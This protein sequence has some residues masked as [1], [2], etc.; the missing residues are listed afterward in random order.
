MG[1]TTNNEVATFEQLKA[2]AA[3]KRR[4]NTTDPLPICGL[5]FRMRSVFEDELSDY[6]AAIQAAKDAQQRHVRLRAANRQ[7]IALVLVD[8][9]G[10]P[11]VP[12]GEVDILRDLDAAD[13]S[14]LY[15]DCVAHCGVNKQDLED[16]V[17]NSE[18][19]TP[20]DSPTS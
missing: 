8:T 17:G 11:L 19:T 9:L 7:F 16:L 18:E 13:S 4:F 12:S 10:N 3:R 2:A 6:Q 5:T 1:G 20:S 15:D 14:R